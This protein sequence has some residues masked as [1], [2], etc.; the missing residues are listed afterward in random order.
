MSETR[1]ARLAAW[2][3]TPAGQL[4]L[5]LTRALWYLALIGATWWC[6]QAP[7]RA[8]PYFRM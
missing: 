1:R 2:L 8:F 6:W 5:E 4:T 7:T 3:A